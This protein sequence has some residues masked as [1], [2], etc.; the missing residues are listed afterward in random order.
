[1]IGR[2]ECAQLAFWVVLDFFGTFLVD[3]EMG[4]EFLMARS[5]SSGG[6][7]S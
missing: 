4:G 2:E 5:I 3:S 7:L 6:V 1:M